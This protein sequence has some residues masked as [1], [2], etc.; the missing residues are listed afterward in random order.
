MSHRA[1]IE[2]RFNLFQSCASAFYT[3]SHAFDAKQGFTDSAGTQ[4][5]A[6]Q[7][8]RRCNQRC[9]VFQ[10]KTNRVL[11]DPRVTRIPAAGNASLRIP[12]VI[13]RRVCRGSF[14]GS[15]FLFFFRNGSR[16]KQV[17]R[18]AKFEDR[19][20]CGLTRDFCFLV[21]AL[22]KRKR[23]FSYIRVGRIPKCSITEIQVLMYQVD[24]FGYL[25]KICFIW[26]NILF[27]A[28]F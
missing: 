4:A 19:E 6:E 13:G 26:F 25:I 1:H 2:S 16:S 9:I 12:R 18:F 11:I 17:A 21:V 10:S 14:C 15:F 27:S 5:R 22:G 23:I 8:R 20:R 7:P 28:R 24:A 3:R